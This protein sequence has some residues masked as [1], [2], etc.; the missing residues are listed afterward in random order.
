MLTD[1]LIFPA[2]AATGTHFEL[3]NFEGLVQRPREAVAQLMALLGLPEP[4]PIGIY[5]A[6]VKHYGGLE[7]IQGDVETVKATIR[8]RYGFEPPDAYCRDLVSFVEALSVARV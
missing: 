7:A 5:D 4:A 6:N 2:L 3:V 1:G 8:E